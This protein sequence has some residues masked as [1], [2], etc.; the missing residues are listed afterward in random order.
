VSA[1][2]AAEANGLEATPLIHF[3]GHNF[4]P[5]HSGALFWPAENTLLVADLHLEKHS[6][7]ARRGNFLPPYDTGLT[8]RRLA[9]D[10]DATS[11]TTVIALGDSFH[12]DYGTATL[13]DA[14]RVVL[15]GLTDRARWIWLSGNHDPSPHALGGDC[16]R[17][18]EHR[19][20]T[21]THHPRRGKTALIAGHLHPAARV[22]INGRSTR[23]P[24]FV[25]DGQT[26]LLPAY[27]SGAGSIN[28]L[29]APFAGLFAWERLQVTMIGRDRLYPVSA[30]RLVSG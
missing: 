21:L 27:G 2:V 8:L 16:H 24:C 13:L 9:A 1:L 17:E 12:R 23:R 6:S 20:L 5:Q 29:S 14:D 22:V 25:H 30:R 18:L 4:I 7:F 11:A 19:G 26:M 28:V 10:L 15:D 3:A